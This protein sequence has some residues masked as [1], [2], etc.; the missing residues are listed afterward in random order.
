VSA[1][2]AAVLFAAAFAAGAVNSIAGG[3]S[4]ISF[5]ALVWSGIDPVTANATNTISISPGA[6]AAMLPFRRELRD[7]GPW[8]RLLGVP[9]IVGGGIG[10]FLLLATPERVFAELVPGLILLATAVFALQETV[11]RGLR[12]ETSPRAL[13]GPPRLSRSPALAVGFQLAIAIY[14]GYFGAGIGIMMLASLGFLGLH[15]LHRMIGLRSFL[16]LCINGVAS[17]YFAASGTVDWPAAL[18]MTA[19]QI[20]GGYGGAA[21]ARRVPRGAVRAAVVAIGVLVAA[22]FFLTRG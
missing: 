8:L 13:A 2:E 19:G 10:A 4:L 20:A 11:A 21:V 14:G 17:V 18:V 1:F 15:D 3:G 22:S 9:S 5:P 16:G 6:L 7:M 12:A